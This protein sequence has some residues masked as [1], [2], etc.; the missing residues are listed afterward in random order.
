MLFID[1]EDGESGYNYLW[2]MSNHCK[3]HVK[4][5]VVHISF[6][7]AQILGRHPFISST[8]YTQ[9]HSTHIKINYQ[10]IGYLLN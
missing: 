6:E 10:L 9:G 2:Y 1:T 4:V 5:P 8:Q 7:L 3:P